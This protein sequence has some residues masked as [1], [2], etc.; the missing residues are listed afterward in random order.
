MLCQWDF[1][2]FLGGI[3]CWQC[4]QAAITPNGFCQS[5]D[6]LCKC[7]SP[8]LHNTVGRK[9][10]PK[11]QNMKHG[12]HFFSERSAKILNLRLHLSVGKIKSSPK[13]SNVMRSK[14]FSFISIAI[15]RSIIRGRDQCEKVC[16][17]FILCTK[18]CFSI[19]KK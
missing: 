15:S 1:Y 8:N 13:G 6:V 7:H 12:G 19:V 5:R 3:S 14:G 4:Y 9:I 2:F 18:T 16:R 11:F 10:L 17:A